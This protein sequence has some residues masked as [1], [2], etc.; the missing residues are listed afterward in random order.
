MLF[1]VSGK[2][3]I[4]TGCA[5]AT[6][7]NSGKQDLQEE[8]REKVNRYMAEMVDEAKGKFDLSSVTGLRDLYVYLVGGLHLIDVTF[9]KSS[10]Q[11]TVTCCTLEILECLWEDYCSGHLNAVVEKCL[12]TEKV[13]D[14]LDM[15]TIML[16][17]TILEEDYV[18]CQLS[19]ME[20][21]GLFFK[22]KNAP[23]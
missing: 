21:S 4:K 1:F 22:C 3:S 14:E 13:K 18:A 11:I 16:T 9:D 10:I 19:L 17:T 2:L 6:S 8:E 5:F 7:R 23:L 12:I 15:E 20:I